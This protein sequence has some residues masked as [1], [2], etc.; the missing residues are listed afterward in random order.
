MFCAGADRWAYSPCE[1]YKKKNDLKSQNN[2][3]HACYDALNLR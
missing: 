3:N 1:V 2:F